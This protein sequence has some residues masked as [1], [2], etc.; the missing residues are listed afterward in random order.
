MS[1]TGHVNVDGVVA[2]VTRSPSD[3]LYSWCATYDL[4][5]RQ[6]RSCARTYDK[7]VGI[8]KMDIDEHRASFSTP[9]SGRLPAGE[10]LASTAR[11]TEDRVVLMK[12][13][14]GHSRAKVAARIGTVVRFKKGHGTDYVITRFNPDGRV[15]VKP[16]YY[17]GNETW[18]DVEALVAMDYNVL[19][20]RAR[21]ARRSGRSHG[22]WHRSAETFLEQIEAWR[23]GGHQN[24]NHWTP[25]I[26]DAGIPLREVKAAD[27]L[28]PAARKRGAAEPVLDNALTKREPF[29]RRLREQVKSASREQLDAYWRHYEYF[30]TR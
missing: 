26:K 28:L 21:A 7:L 5:P 25:I 18:E 20:G 22:D 29:A 8:V 23:E 27:G 15:G 4:G 24:I 14:V 9:R 1:R 13:G 2:F 6:L 16:A 10:A 11:M 17:D 12:N 30:F 3:E 19:E